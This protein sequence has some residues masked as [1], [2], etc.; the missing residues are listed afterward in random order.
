MNKELMKHIYQAFGYLS[1][2]PV[3]GDAVELMAAARRELKTAFSLA[4]GGEDD[5]KQG[6]K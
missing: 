6:D 5:G 2:I 3:A 1:S 4:K